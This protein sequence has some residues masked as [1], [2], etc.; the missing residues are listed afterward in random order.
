MTPNNNR[1]NREEFLAS[2]WEKRPAILR[3]AY[4]APLL[5][6]EELYAAIQNLWGQGGFDDLNPYFDGRNPFAGEASVVLEPREATFEAYCAGI[7]ER[8]GG[9][10]FGASITRLERY[11]E[12]FRSKVAGV[13]D[14][15][16]QQS[17]IPAGFF[18]GGSFFGSYTKTPFEIHTDPAGV[19]TWPVR[20]TKRI[21]VWPKS[22]FDKEP[23]VFD[24]GTHK[25]VL[26]KLENHEK[27]AEVLAAEPGDLMYWP[28]DYW[29]AG[30]GT[31]GYHATVTLSYYYLRSIAGLI[32]KT[33]QASLEARLGPKAIYWGSWDKTSNLPETIKD[34]LGVLRELVDNS[35]IDQSIQRKWNACLENGGFEPVESTGAPFWKD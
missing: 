27:G 19:L 4:D 23:S 20:G 21:L 32:G 34:A 33:V 6:E 15:L 8:L 1:A 7:S 26:D 22:Y 12:I 10:P 11:S 14:F 28:A 13:V 29:H 31:S 30:K 25:Q 35:V 3:G 2:V 16:T 24:L 17:G 18:N 5:T 9:I